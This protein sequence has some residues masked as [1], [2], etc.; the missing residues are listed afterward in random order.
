MR[1]AEAFEPPGG[2]SF[3]PNSEPSFFFGGG[4]RYHNRQAVELDP[5]SHALCETLHLPCKFFL[6]T[7]RKQVNIFWG[8][9]Q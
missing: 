5:I 7:G 8:S 2:G 9:S 4:P 3:Y 1:Y 6:L